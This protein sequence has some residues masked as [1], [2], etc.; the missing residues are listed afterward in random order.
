M[1]GRQ[2][3]EDYL[4]TILQIRQ[5]QGTCRSIDVANRMGFSKP[6]VS[7]A[8]GKLTRSGLLV[9]QEDGELI[10][11]QEGEA[12]AS[13]TLAKHRLL[14]RFFLEIGVSPGQAETDAC[15]IEHSLS[16]ESFQRLRDWR[17][18]FKEG[19]A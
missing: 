18:E 7:V 8:V 2:S 5:E 12:L 9:K 14:T 6:S 13:D 17:A 19:Q 11:T 4:E 10:L 15:A 3:V 1:N 16:E